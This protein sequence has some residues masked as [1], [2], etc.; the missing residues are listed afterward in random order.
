MASVKGTAVSNI[1]I[2]FV[3]LIVQLLICYICLTL[4]SSD[5][6]NRFDCSIVP[7]GL[8]GYFIRYRLKKGV[9]ETVGVPFCASE[10]TED[11]SD[12]ESQDR[13]SVFNSFTREESLWRDRRRGM[14]LQN[15]KD[16]DEIM[17]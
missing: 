16:C 14:S 6:L 13:E 15:T 4:G 8:G 10:L 17:R 2:P 1:V 3:D 9:P 12:V 11:D 7:D 5:Q